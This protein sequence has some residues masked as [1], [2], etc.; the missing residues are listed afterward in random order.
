MIDEEEKNL[1]TVEAEVLS[2]DELIDLL[3]VE[4]VGRDLRISQRSASMRGS[5]LTFDLS[6]AHAEVVSRLGKT[7]LVTRTGRAV[8]RKL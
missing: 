8:Y 2:D 5:I 7:C 3:P 4:S 1:P 6:S